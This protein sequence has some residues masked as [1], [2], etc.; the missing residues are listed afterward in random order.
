[1]NTIASC[2]VS[3]VTITEHHP[4]YRLNVTDDNQVGIPAHFFS[5]AVFGQSRLQ[6][7]LDKNPLLYGQPGGL[8]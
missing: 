3:R 8:T 5:V 4:G 2:L 7:S 6:D 1:M